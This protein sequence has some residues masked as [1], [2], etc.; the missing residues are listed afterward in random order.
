MLTLGRAEVIIFL[1]ITQIVLFIAGSLLF[2][3][4][5]NTRFTV[6]PRDHVILKLS[7]HD[8][9]TGIYIWV[10]FSCRL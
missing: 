1:Y 2:T 6:P 8:K 9:T 10:L 5:P 7:S 3:S 4:D